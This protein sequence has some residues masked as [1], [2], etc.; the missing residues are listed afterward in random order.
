V[1]IAFHSIFC[2]YGFWL[3]NDPRGSW[4]D[5]VASWEL[6]RFG[7]ATKT[8]TR[9][10]VAGK[11][12]NREVREAAKEHLKFP[13]VQWDDEQMQA[14]GRGFANAVEESHYRVLA[15]SILAEHVHMVIGWKD[16]PIRQMVGHLKG[17]ATQQL[18]KEDLWSKAECPVWASRSW[19][20]FIDDVEH[21]QRAILYVE[22]N[23]IKEG[24]PAQRWDF[25]V[26]WA[27]I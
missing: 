11:Q 9:R 16:R 1:I 19:N 6:Y 3:P 13:P 24:K 5:F 26:P 21:L 27:P 22:N 7:P 10:S 15:C 12:H 25:V 14:I 20:V 23:P 4:S 8:E 2:A 17:R 18:T